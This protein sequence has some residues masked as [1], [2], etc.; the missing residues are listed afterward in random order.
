MMRIV[1]ILLLALT[2]AAG[3][4]VVMSLPGGGAYHAGR[5]M[6]VELSGAVEGDEVIIEGDGVL[7]TR[8]A[9]P[10]GREGR[11]VVPL[12]VTGP[13]V[14]GLRVRDGAAYS[15][16]LR[17][18]AE[19]EWLVATRGE[20]P[21]GIIDAAGGGRGAAGTAGV[22]VERMAIERVT[23]EALLAQPHPAEAW[24]GLDAVVLEGAEYATLPERT[25]DVLTAAGCVVAVRADGPPDERW[26][27][28][29]GA[30]QVLPQRVVGPRGVVMN[31]AA[32]VPM[33][34]W[35]PGWSGA[36]RRQLWMAGLAVGAV[37]VLASL[38]RRWAIVGVGMVAAV[39]IVGVMVWQAVTPPVF[40]AGGRVFVHDPGEGAV[41][42]DV[43]AYQTAARE[44][45]GAYRVRGLTWPAFAGR[46]HATQVGMELR[47]AVDGTPLGWSY[48]LKRG[49]A[50]AFVSRGWVT[51]SEPGSAVHE[52]GRSSA[53]RSLVGRIYRDATLLGGAAGSASNLGRVHMQRR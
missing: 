6:A 11:V 45:A 25:I 17:A 50:V 28:A 36:M 51:D 32:Y 5:Y 39:G 14:S 53:M 30:W 20:V 40:E 18:M 33:Q 8:V 42:Q 47:C 16:R 27:V 22:P 26:W 46:L 9:R 52:A 37:G 49:G 7:T 3:A 21:E 48:R 1:A 44:T 13:Q 24:T 19:G 15:G 31:E 12:L 41:Q 23:V 4:E 34:A 38:W 43:W 2:S 35:L 10:A 29:H